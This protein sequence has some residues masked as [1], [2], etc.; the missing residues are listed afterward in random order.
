[1]SQHRLS[2]TK[3]IS[4]NILTIFIFNYIKYLNPFYMH[5]LLK[6]H[7]ENVKGESKLVIVVSIDV[8]DFSKFSKSKD[9]SD[10]AMFISKFYLKIIEQF[11]DICE[12]FFFKPTGDGLLICIPYSEKN[13]KE[14]FEETIN[15]SMNCHKEFNSM[16]DNIAVI[17]F[18]T[19][20]FIGIGISRG[21]A[22]EIKSNNGNKSLTLDYSGHKLN[23]A[24]RLQDIARPSGIVFES[25]R[26]LN[27]LPKEIKD[28]FVVKKLY[29]KSLAEDKPIS[30]CYLKDHVEIRQ[31]N[32][33]PI[34]SQ[35][36]IETREFSKKQLIKG[37][38]DYVISLKQGKIDRSL[39][40]V[41]ILRP[42]IK[43][44]DGIDGEITFDL[45][46]DNDYEFS[47]E[48][49]ESKVLLLTKKIIINHGD[50]INVA[51]V[52][53]KIQFIVKYRLD[54]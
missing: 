18:A 36:L 37:N 32:M 23:L 26:D 34:S 27:L 1:M 21:S 46:E 42:G 11:E 44:K 22:S 50:F 15:I 33:E 14:R 49:G 28:L 6:E 31:E 47:Q 20:E 53:D 40:D 39:I 48:S 3:I 9:S 10:V 24:S 19:P 7:L 54:K 2:I 38:L 29:V 12:D 16:F 5:N 43:I 41:K 51:R 4:F 35:W 45:K 13:L 25:E 8:R 17:N 30:V 52:K